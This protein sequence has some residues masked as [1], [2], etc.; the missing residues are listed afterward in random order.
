MTVLILFMV[1][2]SNGMFPKMHIPGYFQVLLFLT[3]L[4]G[5]VI[6]NKGKAVVNKKYVPFYLAMIALQLITIA[7]NGM[8]FSLDMFL[9]LSLTCGLLWCSNISKNEFVD[10][11]RNAIMI[12]AMGSI[13]F[14]LV[15]LLTNIYKI[16]PRFCLNS[17]DFD[18]TYTIFGTF[19][20]IART[21]YTYYRNYG[22]FSEPGQFQIFLSIGLIF[23]LYHCEDINWKRLLVYLISY[24][25]CD[26]TNGYITGALIVISYLFMTTSRKDIDRSEKILRRVLWCGCIGIV[27]VACIT[28][29]SNS[30]IMG[31]M[32]KIQGLSASYTYSSVGTGIE[33][34]RAFDV[35]LKIFLN[36]PITGLGYRG[37]ITYISNLSSGK[38]IMT[39]SPLNWFARFGLVY[40]ILANTSYICMFLKKKGVLSTIALIVAI[41]SMI[42]AQAVGSDFMTCIIMMYGFVDAKRILIKRSKVNESYCYI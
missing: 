23:E 42:S 28:Y 21:P 12:I 13:A 9:M 31:V 17:T 29:N 36:N 18:N 7:I 30:F 25:T 5:Y 24:I 20:A 39:C 2:I 40:G 15:G 10:G 6:Y 27:I 8:Y 33:R 1:W 37:M 41:F 22:I 4:V 19:V 38:F 14:Y 32:E 16:I 11:Y 26:S 34:R 35:A 3:A